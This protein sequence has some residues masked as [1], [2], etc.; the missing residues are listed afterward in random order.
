M[1]A[2]SDSPPGGNQK[3]EGRLPCLLLLLYCLNRIDSVTAPIQL[4]CLGSW[5]LLF[6]GGGLLVGVRSTGRLG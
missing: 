4:L 6:L 3:K 2:M 1:P 5:L